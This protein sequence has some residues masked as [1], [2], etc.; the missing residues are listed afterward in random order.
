MHWTI[1]F[2]KMYFHPS[3]QRM[4]ILP[5]A[6]NAHNSMRRVSFSNSASHAEAP[7]RMVDVRTA[8]NV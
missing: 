3:T 2:S 8:F 7:V 1:G 4:V 5:A 6:S